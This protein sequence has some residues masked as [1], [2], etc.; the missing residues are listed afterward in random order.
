MQIFT[1]IGSPRSLVWRHT[2]WRQMAL[3]FVFFFVL[4]ADPDLIVLRL[5]SCPPLNPILEKIPFQKGTEI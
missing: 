2:S 4:L 5:D 1:S 3:H